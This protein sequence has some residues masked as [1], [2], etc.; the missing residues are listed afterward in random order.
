MS[1]HCQGLPHNHHSV[2]SMLTE[3]GLMPDSGV[4]LFKALD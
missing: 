3:L 2:E 4:Q 1:E